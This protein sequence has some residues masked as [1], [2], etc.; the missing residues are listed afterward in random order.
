ML[1]PGQILCHRRELGP[2][3]LGPRCGDI[4]AVARSMASF[5]LARLN[6]ADARHAAGDADH[7]GA[8]GG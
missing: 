3:R 4:S 6:V 5:G 2:V 1:P 8:V 7:L